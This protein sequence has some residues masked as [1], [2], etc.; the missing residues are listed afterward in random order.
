[1]TDMLS[2]RMLRAFSIAVVMVYVAVLF[3]VYERYNGIDFRVLLMVFLPLH[4]LFM[5]SPTGFVNTRRL[6][7]FVACILLF[8]LVLTEFYPSFASHFYLLALLYMLNILALLLLA[9]LSLL[10]A[11]Q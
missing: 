5:L 6:L 11:T 9:G 4:L 3:D 10:A 1:M 2:L 8:L 7:S